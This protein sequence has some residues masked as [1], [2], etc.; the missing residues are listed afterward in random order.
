MTTAKQ[1]KPKAVEKKLSYK[2]QKELDELPKKMGQ[3]ATE[4]QAANDAMA[5]PGF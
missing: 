4:I 2:D 3:L 5:K 1:E